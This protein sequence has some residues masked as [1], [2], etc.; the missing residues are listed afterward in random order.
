[1]CS[2]IRFTERLKSKSF[3]NDFF[4]QIKF[5]VRTRKNFRN[6]QLD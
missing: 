5:A 2:D 4:L 3:W 1:M 6:F